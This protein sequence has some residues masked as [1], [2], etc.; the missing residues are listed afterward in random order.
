MTWCCIVFA[1]KAPATPPPKMTTFF[2]NIFCACSLLRLDYSWR[3]LCNDCYCYVL[4]NNINRCRCVIAWIIR[5][6]QKGKKKKRKKEK[7]VECQIL[8]L[9]IKRTKAKWNCSCSQLATFLVHNLWKVCFNFSTY[10]FFRKIL[11]KKK[12][13]KRPHYNMESNNY[14]TNSFNLWYNKKKKKKREIKWL[15]L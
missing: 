3:F 5:V 8:N 10:N 6:Y 1:R 13:E 14:I 4:T 11:F 12:K 7:R 15:M 2:S 9:D